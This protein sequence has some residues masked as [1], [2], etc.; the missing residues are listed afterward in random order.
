M[1]KGT[2]DTL[3]YE[4]EKYLEDALALNVIKVDL[5]DPFTI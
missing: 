5:G 1:L 2:V 3:A 4:V